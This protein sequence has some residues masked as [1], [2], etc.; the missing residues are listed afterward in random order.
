MIGC[1]FEDRH[2]P[3]HLVFIVVV[4]SFQ[5][6]ICIW[7]IGISLYKISFVREIPRNSWVHLNLLCRL[8]VLLYGVT[9]TQW[10]SLTLNFR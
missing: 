5:Y 7:G 10:R 9:P 2:W 3:V 1:P 4:T 8:A 6:G